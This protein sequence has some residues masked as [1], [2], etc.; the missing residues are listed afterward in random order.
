MCSERGTRVFVTVGTDHHPFDRLVDWLDDWLATVRAQVECSAQI[1]S[2]RAPRY[3]RWAR[4][5]SYPEM[6][7]AFAD[8]DVVVCHGGPGTI[9][10]ALAAGKKPLVVPRFSRLGEHVDDHQVVFSRRISEQDMI[11]L[12]ESA[13]AFRTHLQ[14]SLVAPRRFAA[15]PRKLEGSVAVGRL[16]RMV[17][18]LVA[19]GEAAR[20]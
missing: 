19:S 5:L 17:D 4:H 9:M 18:E 20:A 3:A 13:G 2:S 10:L 11:W 1:G 6:R 8:A 14:S 12:A 15:D 16:E 7:A